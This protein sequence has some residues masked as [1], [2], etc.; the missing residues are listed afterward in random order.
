ML[1]SYVDVTQPAAASAPAIKSGLSGLTQILDLAT[2]HSQIDHP[3]CAKCLENVKRELQDSIVAAEA[4]ASAYEAALKSLLVLFHA[5]PLDS[6]SLTHSC[7]SHWATFNPI[8]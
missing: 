6:T 3:I 4:Q 8:A 7:E 5:S 2:T 1:E